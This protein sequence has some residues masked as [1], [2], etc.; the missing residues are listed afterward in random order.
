MDPEWQSRLWE[1]AQVKILED[2]VAYPLH[3]R[4]RVYIRRGYL[5]YG[6]LLLSS[7]ALY[8]QIT[9]ETRVLRKS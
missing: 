4:K 8:P 6:H 5:D 3:Y 2:M 9:E 1:Y 7:M